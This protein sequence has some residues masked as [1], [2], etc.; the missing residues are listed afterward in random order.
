M[1]D[2]AFRPACCVVFLSGPEDHPLYREACARIEE[3]R[4]KKLTKAK[5]MLQL[6]RENE[7]LFFEAEREAADKTLEVREG[8]LS[9]RMPKYLSTT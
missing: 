9:P 8:H 6:K 4:Q 7:Q 1:A 2:V 3:E 5:H